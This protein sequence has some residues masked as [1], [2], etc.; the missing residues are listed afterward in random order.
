MRWRHDHLPGLMSQYKRT[1]GLG[2]RWYANGDTLYLQ[3]PYPL[4]PHLQY[5][6]I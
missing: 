3:V 1:K 5:L 4:W 6:I 2:G